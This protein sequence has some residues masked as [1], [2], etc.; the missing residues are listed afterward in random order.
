MLRSVVHATQEAKQLRK[1][2]KF[3][4]EGL[5]IVAKKMAEE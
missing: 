5:E 3:S 2:T 4:E 1:V